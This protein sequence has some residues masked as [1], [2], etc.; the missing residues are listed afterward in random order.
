VS[1]LVIAEE[2]WEACSEWQVGLVE[3]EDPSRRDLLFCQFD[4]VDYSHIYK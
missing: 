4:W 2:K 3:K 1:S